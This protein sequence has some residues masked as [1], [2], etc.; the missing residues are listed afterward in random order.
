MCINCMIPGC[1]KKPFKYCFKKIIK[2]LNCCRKN[3]AYYVNYDA[4]RPEGDRP[5]NLHLLND[6]IR[7]EITFSGPSTLSTSRKRVSYQDEVSDKTDFRFSRVYPNLSSTFKRKLT[8]YFAYGK[9]NELKLTS[10]L[11]I[12]GVCVQVYYDDETKLITDENGKNYLEE[13]P[14]SKELLMEYY[15][16]IEQ[17]PLPELGRDNENLICFK[18]NLIVKFTDEGFLSVE[19]KKIQG[20]RNPTR[21]ELSKISS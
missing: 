17:R 21:L 19:G 9:F 13:L 2:K 14:P 7:D 3:E 4:T 20:L 11:M 6:N 10:Y 8:W 16:E 5:V 15:S 12:D 18:E 1:L